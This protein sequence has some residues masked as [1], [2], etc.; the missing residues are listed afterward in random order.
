MQ[1]PG[2]LYVIAAPSGT[3]KT[4]LVDS[5]VQKMT[6][7][8]LS[9]SY[10]TRPQRAK[11]QDGVHYWFVNQAEF[12]AMIAKGV[13]LEY[14]R[15]FGLDNYYGTSRDWVEQQLQQGQDVILEIDWQG[16]RQ[17]RSLFP[18]AVTIF[19]LPPSLE[20]L[21]QRLQSRNQDDADIIAKRLAAAGSE[22]S[23]YDEF[24][25]IVIND[26]FEKALNDL[27]AII[28]ATRLSKK[29]QIPHYEHLLR[30][31]LRDFSQI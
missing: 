7:L 9:I 23:H 6:D 8:K 20:L 29:K 13:F 27:E 21:Q 28:R 25:Y 12:E 18:E 16:A 5:L 22:L 26:V 3:G 15:V 14:A 2:T 17:I 24:D 19:I 1:T 10:T 31:L 11:E 4:S 30:D